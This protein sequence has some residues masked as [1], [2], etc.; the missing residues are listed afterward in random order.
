MQNKEMI[1]NACGKTLSMENGI[2][3]EDACCVTKEWGYFSKK[4]GEIHTF[5]LCE[6]CYDK[7]IKTFQIP[8]EIQEKT[9]WL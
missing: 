7:M 9:E 2:C 8:V 4:D 6:D 5:L 3:Q 1:C